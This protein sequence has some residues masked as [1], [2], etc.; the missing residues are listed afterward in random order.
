MVGAVSMTVAAG[1]SKSE[2]PIVG[3]GR[4]QIVSE[5]DWPSKNADVEAV[6]S[7]PQKYRAL[8]QQSPVPVL[9]PHD[10]GYLHAARSVRPCPRGRLFS[11]AQ[12]RLQ[13]RCGRCERTGPGG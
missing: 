2:A 12:C 3:T 4:T 7:L 1:C 8:I 10:Q 5:I 11:D 6:N 13:R 9:V